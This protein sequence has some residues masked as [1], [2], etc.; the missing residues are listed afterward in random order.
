[1]IGQLS[2]HRDP[3]GVFPRKRTGVLVVPLRGEKKPGFVPLPQRVPP[4]CMR[5]KRLNR[6]ELIPRSVTHAWSDQEYFCTPLDGMLVHRRDT[7]SIKFAGA[8]LYTCVERGNCEG[9]V[10]C[11]RSQ[12]NVPGQGSNP[13]FS[14]SGALTKR[15]PRLPPGQPN[16]LPGTA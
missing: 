11:P 3:G 4:V 9:K 10:P 6:P 12:R 2:F 16:P 5:S 15:P 1:M 8:H 13:N 7:P 14:E